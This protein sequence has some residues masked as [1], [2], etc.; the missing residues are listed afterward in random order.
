MGFYGRCSALALCLAL[1]V[2]VSAGKKEVAPVRPQPAA[3]YAAHDSHDGVTIAA[4]P[5]DKPEK[6]KAVFGKY[7]PLKGGYLPVFLVITN[8]TEDA[9]RLD[10]LEVQFVAADRRRVEPTP[11]GIVSLRLRGRR[12]PPGGVEP[13][14]PLPIPRLPQRTDP[15]AISELVDRE[16]VLKMVPPG[17]TVGGFLFFHVGLEHDVLSGARL[18]LPGISWARTGKPL[19]FFEVSFDDYLGK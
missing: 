14:R 9:L 17:E 10:N 18:Y 6:S 19:M 3:T 12:M 7:D 11:A 8:T 15:N 5:Y 1:A 2:T 16:F 4:E 13:P